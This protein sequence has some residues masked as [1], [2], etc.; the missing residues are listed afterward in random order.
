M[1][2]EAT[3][4]RLCLRVAAHSLRF[5]RP[6]FRSR[7]I[8]RRAA[9]CPPSHALS[10]VSAP[11]RTGGVLVACRGS[12]FRRCL[13]GRLR[14]ACRWSVGSWSLAVHVFFASQG[15]GAL[16]SCLTSACKTRRLTLRSNGPSTAGA[17]GPVRGTLYIFANRAKPA[18]RG[19]PFS[20][21]VSR[22]QNRPCLT[23]QARGKSAPNETA[24]GASVSGAVVLAR[25]ERQGAAT[26]VPHRPDG[27][28]FEKSEL[29]NL[30][31]SSRSLRAATR[32][33]PA[34]CHRLSFG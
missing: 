7:L 32:S 29:S 25:V 30:P 2:V 31:L 6:G 26:L 3:Q 10:R 27:T 24:S 18:Y 20:S 28:R 9:P 8:Y 16:P 19:G 34:R 23:Q 21:N 33:R 5:R 12:T 4:F 22:Q 11:C 17:L 15:A 13:R 1:L 14:S